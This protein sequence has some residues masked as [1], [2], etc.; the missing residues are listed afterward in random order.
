MAKRYTK[1]YSNY[2]LSK[3]HQHTT[4]GTIWERDW[5]TIGNDHQIEPGKRSF[6]YDG[7]FL[8][9]TNNFVQTKKKRKVS[10]YKGVWNYDDVENA[11]PVVNDVKVNRNSND[12]RDFAYYGSATELFRTSVENIVKWFPGR[13]TTSDQH[14]TAYRENGEEV[15]GGFIIENPYNIDLYHIVTDFEGLNKLRY[16]ESSYSDY[17]C[18]LNGSDDYYP[19]IG[20]DIKWRYRMFNGNVNYNKLN[21]GNY[22]KLCD[23]EVK[24]LCYEYDEE[25][26]LYT[27]KKVINESVYERL[28][29]EQCYNVS[30]NYVY[31]Y[32]Y[33]CIDNYEKLFEITLTLYN[34]SENGIIVKMPAYLV[35]D[36]IVF[37]TEN[38]DKLTI[39]PNQS[40]ID[41]YFDNLDGFEK[42]L[43]TRATD[44]LYTNTFLT[45]FETER[46]Y[47]YRYR[48]Y[49]W[50]S[51]DG[52]ISVSSLGFEN[53][54]NDMYNLTEQMDELWCDNIWRNM[55]H[56]S[57]KNYDR[58]YTRLYNEGDENEF[59]EGGSRIEKLIRIYGR[60][61]D[62]IKR[63]IDGI[64]LTTEV[65]Y[66]GLNNMP[67][68]EISDKT[69]YKGWEIY[70]TIPLLYTEH[71]EEIVNDR[72]D[73][74]RRYGYEW[75]TSEDTNHKDFED[76]DI[77]FNR[78]LSVSSK[79]LSK[80]KGTKESIEM[81]MALFGFGGDDFTI[82]E[83]YRYTVPKEFSDDLAKEFGEVNSQENPDAIYGDYYKEIP[84]EDIYLNENRYIAPYF[85]ENKHYKGNIAFQSDGA[86]GFIASDS[87]YS[88]T[89]PYLRSVQNISELLSV[90]PF[91]VS[92]YDMFYVESL[93]DY[94]QYVEDAFDISN[95]FYLVNSDNPESFSSWRS[96]SLS[97]K[98][99]KGTFHMRYVVKEDSEYIEYITEEQWKNL[100]DD[101]KENYESFVNTLTKQQYEDITKD[102]VQGYDS[103]LRDYTQYEEI[104]N[105]N[106]DSEMYNKA[107][108]LDSITS[109]ERGNNPHTGYGKYD[110]GTKFDEYMQN[111]FKY[112]LENTVIDDDEIYTKAYS[113][114]LNFSLTSL[115]CE[116]M[117]GKVKNLAF[118]HDRYCYTDKQFC[119]GDYCY[120]NGDRYADAITPS[121][122]ENLANEE[123]A[124]Y[125]EIYAEVSTGELVEKEVYDAWYDEW[126]LPDHGTVGPD[127]IYEIEYVPKESIT[128]DMYESLSSESELKDK[129]IRIFYFYKKNYDVIDYI[130]YNEIKSPINSEED[131]WKVMSP[132]YITKSLYNS[133]VYYKK[134]NFNTRFIYVDGVTA[135]NYGEYLAKTEEEKL[136]YTREFITKEQYDM[137]TEA[138]KTQ[139]YSWR[140]F[141]DIYEQ[142]SQIDKMIDETDEI[143]Y[144]EE[145]LRKLLLKAQSDKGTRYDSFEIDD[146][147]AKL[148]DIKY[149]S[150]CVP[151]DSNV[152]TCMPKYYLNSK[153]LTFVNNLT[154]DIFEYVRFYYVNYGDEDDKIDYKD[155]IKLNDEQKKDYYKME[156]TDDVISQEEY[157]QLSYF[158]K[159][160]R[161]SVKK[162]VCNKYFKQY[163]FDIIYPYI[164]QVIPSTTML[165][166][167]G[168]DV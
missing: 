5:V 9:T 157:D 70:T 82:V 138:E 75:F 44:P 2:I 12:V 20:Y 104:P 52:F 85:D 151:Y 8:F 156:D 7:N 162:T 123:Q 136:L 65:T 112:M 6:Y 160:N 34:G 83:N 43:L 145:K 94:N 168:F 26:D 77:D 47:V 45:P 78:A 56:E 97:D 46:G 59:I 3:K 1:L 117:N 89:V 119:N 137:L 95:F 23:N 21:Q 118:D 74:L 48:K 79:F 103:V 35:N 116:W 109:D 87:R 167:E 57:I 58:T 49:T 51:V 17:V 93:S 130:K 55:T 36:S 148:Y 120:N 86:W 81:V 53:Y 15:I 38:D 133:F 72:K 113:E 139:Y 71:E 60:V 115:D 13:L 135:I 76:T 144:L 128:E 90:N 163:F 152:I 125:D 69:N 105:P 100:P 102:Y 122:Y 31:P 141:F 22:D 121:E 40:V 19:I 140:D 149:N 164:T 127:V 98:L 39:S 165:R 4:K 96:V 67:D 10:E 64:K 124:C 16:F 147:K 106:F 73:F 50:P 33:K 88:E 111:P 54:V 108:Y 110:F 132:V 14:L 28:I 129:Y 107:M 150:V 18:S 63:E 99:Y 134:D 154:H 42:Q 61:F 159:L 25:T 62:D 27:P 131:E 80:S 91:T 29:S 41:E 101:E 66:N 142:D 146:I 161:D 68:A 37:V 92:S 32:N 126:S 84:V 143:P 24:K 30:N 114:D 158:D 11:S 153:I 155:Y 166:F